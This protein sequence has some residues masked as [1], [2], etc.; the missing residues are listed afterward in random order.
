MKDRK[1]K[2]VSVGVGKK[3]TEMRA[4]TTTLIYVLEDGETYTSEKPRPVRV[5]KEQLERIEAGEKVYHVVPDWNQLKR[6]CY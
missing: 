3:L 4:R 1:R 5:T 6:D 2:V